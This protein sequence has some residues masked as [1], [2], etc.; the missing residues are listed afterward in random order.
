MKGFLKML[1]NT[2]EHQTDVI[3]TWDKL[4]SLPLI[5]EIQ[6]DQK[7]DKYLSNLSPDTPWGDRKTAAQQLG[8]M[9]CQEAVPGLLEVL[10]T[11]PFWMVRCS[12]IQAL[13]MIGNPNAISTLR[14]VAE[15]DS[16][17]VVRSYAV[18]AIDRLS[19]ASGDLWH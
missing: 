14:A 12:I 17:Q 5:F 8:S 13:E 1:P 3:D 4:T 6:R 11:D 18:K 2:Y 9:R 16:F 10:P 19:S 15:N 7:L